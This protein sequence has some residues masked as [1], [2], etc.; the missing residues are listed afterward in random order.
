MKNRHV[1]GDAA[2]ERQL[3]RE[4]HSAIAEAS[5]NDLL[6][7]LYAIVSNAF[8]D[9]LLYEALVPQTRTALGQH[10]A[11]LMMN[12]RHFGC[13]QKQDPDLAVKI[14]RAC[15]GIGQVA[16][17]VSDI[18]AKLLREKEKQVSHLIKK[19]SK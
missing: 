19:T 18:P 8:P 14:H 7:K 1:E 16:G 13:I 4:F 11:A 9:W 3:S 17:D 5:R 15:D 10:G 12:T 2:S 6:I